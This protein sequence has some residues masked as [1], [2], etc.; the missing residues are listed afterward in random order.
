MDHCNTKGTHKSS[1]GSGTLSQMWNIFF[2]LKG[3]NKVQTRR[4]FLYVT[5]GIYY[6]GK[7]ITSSEHW[8]K[9]DGWE[10]NVM[11]GKKSDIRWH[12]G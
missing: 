11:T 10:R 7:L 4:V 2:Q 12:I 3:D 1:F 8:G 6:T 9:S 5:A